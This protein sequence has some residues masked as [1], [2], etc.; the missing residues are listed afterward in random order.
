MR[1][2][3]GSSACE[4][5]QDEREDQRMLKK[6]NLLGAIVAVTFYVSAI[7]VFIFRLLGKPSIRELDWLF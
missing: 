6:M 7:L 1:S 4:W 2:S 3:I 5:K